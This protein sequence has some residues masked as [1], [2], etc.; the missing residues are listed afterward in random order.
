MW[1][2]IRKFRWSFDGVVYNDGWS[3]QGIRDYAFTTAGQK[4]VALRVTDN[5]RAP[6]P[7]CCCHYDS[8]CS[9]ADEEASL[10][11]SVTVVKVDDVLDWVTQDEGP[12]YACLCDDVYL[13][14]VPFPA[15]YYPEDEPTW[16]I[17]S[18]PS[19]ASA[20]VTACYDPSLAIL[21]GMDKEGWYT[22]EASC[23]SSSSSINVYGATWMLFEKIG[24]TLIDTTNNYSENATI[25]VTAEDADCGYCPCFTETINILEDTSDPAYVA[26]YS[27][28]G[29]YLPSS[30]TFTATDYGIKTFVAKSLAGPK[31]DGTT[32]PNVAKIKTTSY[33]MVDPSGY[34]T[35]P[36]WIDL[37]QVHSLSSGAAYDWF[38]SRTLDIFAGAT[39]DLAT[40]LSKMS[41]YDQ[42]ADAS[43]WGQ[44]IDWDHS[45]TTGVY[46]NPHYNAVR[47][48]GTATT[49]CGDP[50]TKAHTNLVIHEARHCYQDYLSSADL[51]SPNDGA[52]PNNDDDC[53]WLVD[54]V[55]IAP[56]TIILDTGTARS[57][58][59]GNDSF[60][61][62]GTFDNYAS[63]GTRSESDNVIEKDAYTYGDNND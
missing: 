32:P 62:D 63:G 57:K 29:G 14:A 7:P 33:P 25:S 35:V 12:L 22:V 20:T 26:I 39:G 60:S 15:G 2:G 56:T 36:Q 51:G 28:N 21:S 58:C 38:E 46:F 30:L 42:T 9:S 34:L 48:D 59:T 4:S 23:G 5:D 16:A 10:V 54:S 17:T 44:I 3:T 27:Q 6:E 37:S 1:Y 40:V 49:I 61:G 31:T 24:N 47:I 19:G 50:R 41:Y 52:G 18:Q 53:D 55:P 8:D 13:E 43:Y 11:R 45:A